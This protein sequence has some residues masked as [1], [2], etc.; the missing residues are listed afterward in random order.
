MH[1]TWLANPVVV[2]KENGKWRLCIDFIDLNKACPKDPFP[3]LR[4]DQIEDS[5]FGCDLLS[6]LDAYSRYHQILMSK[7]DEEK[8]SFI[9]PCGTYCFVRMPFGLKSAGSTFAR[10]VQIGFEPQLHRNIEA[11][12]DDIVVKTKDKSTLI[13]D[14]EEIFANLRKINLKLNLEKCVFGVPSGKLLGFFVSHREI[15]ANPDKIKAIEQIHAPRTVKDVR[16]LTGCI[17]ALSRFISKSAERALPFFK[18]LKKEG[19]MKW[20]PEA[21]AALQELKAYLSSVPTLVAPRPQEPLLL[22][23]AATN[24]VVSAA[25]V[26]QREVEEAESEQITAESERDQDSNEHG[27]ESNPKDAARKKMMQHPVYFISS[28]LQGARSRYSGVQ[29]LIFGLIM[30]SRKLRHYFQAHEITV[31]TCFPLQRILR[32]PEATGRIVEWASELSS[33]GMKVERTSMIQSRA[34]VEFIAEWMPTPDEEVPET[35]IPGKE[36]P[37]EWIMYFDSAFSLQG[38]RAGVLLVA[39]SEEHLKYV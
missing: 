37:Q 23:L 35:V 2:R 4:I 3:L 10:A 14:M 5:T 11:Y 7:E 22:Y 1:P 20:T 39:H 24:Q 38:A 36:S 32:N 8:T 6:L 13:Q 12:M 19:P 15:E 18:I 25:L 26:A 21:D 29:K 9:T 27:N 33:F 16:L 30:A 28:L 17:A 34:L 31:V